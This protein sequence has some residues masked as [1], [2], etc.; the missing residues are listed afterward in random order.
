MH[1]PQ[2]QASLS[3]KFIQVGL[4]DVFPLLP[5]NDVLLFEPGAT[6]L[7]TANAD[8]WCVLLVHW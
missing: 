3:W 7:G 8:D 2:G 6:K 1:L 4:K 5:H